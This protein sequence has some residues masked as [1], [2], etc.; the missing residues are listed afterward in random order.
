[1]EV[2]RLTIE[3][4]TRAQVALTASERAE[5]YVL[6]TVLFAIGLV[7]A[8]MGSKLHSVIAGRFMLAFAAASIILAGLTAATFPIRL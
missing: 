4:Q 7:F 1:M 5:N 3:A 2:D 6:L 8:S